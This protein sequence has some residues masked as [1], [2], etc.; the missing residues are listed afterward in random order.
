MIVALSLA[1]AAGC[2]VVRPHERQDL[3]R[4]SMTADR[5]KGEGRA[6]Q[7]RASAR[8]GAEGGTGEPGGGCGCN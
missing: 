7:H 5:G 2:A 4:R 1:G 3:A 6:D 8:E